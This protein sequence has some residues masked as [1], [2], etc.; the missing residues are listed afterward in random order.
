MTSA[1]RISCHH[2]PFGNAVCR[3]I[4]TAKQRN[5]DTLT[6]TLYAPFFFWL[7][8]QPAEEEW[9]LLFL[10]SVC[11]LRRKKIRSQM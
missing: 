2:S 10:D 5:Y 7:L 11:F 3:F 1:V 4:G 9:S 8:M 6:M